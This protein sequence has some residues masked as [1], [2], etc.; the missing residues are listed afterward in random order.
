MSLQKIVFK[1]LIAYMKYM[2]ILIPGNTKI[3]CLLSFKNKSRTLL[4]P[5]WYN[6]WISSSVDIFSIKA[7]FNSSLSILHSMPLLQKKMMTFPVYFNNFCLTL[8]LTYSCF[9][10]CCITVDF[11]SRENTP[12]IYY[13]LWNILRIIISPS[14]FECTLLIRKL[15]FLSLLLFLSG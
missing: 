7:V 10:F 13:T 2:A 11:F 5:K 4:I 8:I 15:V 12:T 1:S 6:I 14:N 3:I 9:L